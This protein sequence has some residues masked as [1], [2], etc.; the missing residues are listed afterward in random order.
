M[1]DRGQEL[2]PTLLLNAYAAG[3]FP[4]ADS[5]DDPEV[6]WVDPAFRGVIPLPEFHVPKSLAKRVKKGD[7]S[8]TVDTAF[9]AVLD[10]C[11]ARSET[12]INDEIRRLYKALHEIGYGHSVEVWSREGAL[13]GG[14]YGVALGGAFFGESMF[15]AAPDGSKLALVHLIA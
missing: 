3:V 15:S 1:S 10:G 6:F 9:E 4:M 2:T 14:L 12:W 8:I 7:F 5:A 13:I 11:A